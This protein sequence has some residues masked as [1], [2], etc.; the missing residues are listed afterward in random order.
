MIKHAFINSL[1]QAVVFAISS[2][3]REMPLGEEKNSHFADCFTQ[4]NEDNLQCNLVMQ[5]Q[6]MGLMTNG[7]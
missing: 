4:C 2:S 3:Q 6:E 7:L 5:E 1:C